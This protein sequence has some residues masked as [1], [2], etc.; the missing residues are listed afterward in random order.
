MRNIAG[1]FFVVIVPMLI[2]PMEP[3]VAGE[4]RYVIT[5]GGADVTDNGHV[6]FFPVGHRD[7]PNVASGHS[8]DSVQMPDGTY[9]VHLLFSDGAAH[10]DVWLADQKPLRWR[11]RLPRCGW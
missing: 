9:D 10:K 2:W 8:G 4:A 1:L 7:D 6:L 3:A 5:N 11:C